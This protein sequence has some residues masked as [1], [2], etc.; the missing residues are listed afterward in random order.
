[1]KHTYKFPFKL[2]F[3]E[4]GNLPFL[5]YN[6]ITIVE[7]RVNLNN[8]WHLIDAEHRSF[9]E[10]IG[11]EIIFAERAKHYKGDFTKKTEMKSL[12]AG[13][14]NIFVIWGII[15]S[16]AEMLGGTYSLYLKK[17]GEKPEK[18]IQCEIDIEWET[19]VKKIRKGVHRLNLNVSVTLNEFRAF[20]NPEYRDLEELGNS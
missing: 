17:I 19:P 10:I 5:T 20:S 3:D 8:K 13:K 14:N 9:S 4:E 11:R 16:V 7:S 6:G 1:M 15:D 2:Q 18:E 12:K